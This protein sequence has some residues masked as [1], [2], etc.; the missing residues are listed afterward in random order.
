MSE[1]NLT[2]AEAIRLLVEYLDNELSTG[3]RDD[4]EHHL[5]ICRS[6][7]ARH[8]FE[9][10]LKEQIAGLASETIRPEFRSRL[11]SLVDRLA[12]EASESPDSNPIN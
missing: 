10:G 1:K 3:R 4:L 12:H 7:H 9:R 11:R 6:C 8:E 5:E 2:C